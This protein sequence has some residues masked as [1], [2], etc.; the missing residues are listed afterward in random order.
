MAILVVNLIW[1]QLKLQQVSTP[2]RDNK[3]ISLRNK[4][5]LKME[6]PT[7]NPDVV[8]D[9]RNIFKVG[10]TYLVLPAYIKDM[11]EGSSLQ[12]A[13]PYSCQQVYSFMSIRTY[14]FSYQIFSSFTF[15]MLSQKSPIPSSCPAPQTTH[16]CMLARHSPVL[17]HL[18]F[19][20]PRASLL[21]DGQLGH[22]LL[23]MQLETQ[24]WEVLVS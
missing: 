23:H 13:S 24:I 20:K 16:F 7:F 9:R 15:Q 8:E 18:I 2:L 6:R 10:H 12:R 19:T 5:Q 14:F 1:N 3:S 11:E 17:G 4:S 21:I 22:P